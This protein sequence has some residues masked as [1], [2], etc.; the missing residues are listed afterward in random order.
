MTIP[1]AM[2]SNGALFLKKTAADYLKH[3]LKTSPCKP[4]ATAGPIQTAHCTKETDPCQ[5]SD[6]GPTAEHQLSSAQEHLQDLDVIH[7]LIS[8]RGCS[9]S[10]VSSIV[11][12]TFL[13]LRSAVMCTW[14]AIV[15]ADPT[16]RTS[17]CAR[18]AG[19]RQGPP[20]YPRPPPLA[21]SS[22]M[23]EPSVCTI[24]LDG[25]SV[26]PRLDSALAY[27]NPIRVLGLT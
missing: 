6:N 7:R 2:G 12:T 17:N 27:T 18:G 1:A 9:L 3:D 13:V 5:P 22:L 10:R 16:H 26:S 8:V 25:C 19:G 20:R 15:R 4:A 11:C 24:T 14:S 21:L 23:P